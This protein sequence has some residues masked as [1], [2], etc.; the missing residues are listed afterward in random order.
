[1]ANYGYSGAGQGYSSDGGRYEMSSFD[2]A[3]SY[4]QLSY[5][6]GGKD[7]TTAFYDEVSSIQDEIR[8]FNANVLKISEMHTRSLNSI[9]DDATR[10]T[11]AQLEGL[12]D[13][14]RGLSGELKR[15][16]KDLE[17]RGGDQAKKQQTSF[18]KSK[19]M[20]SIQGYQQV[21]REYRTKYKQRIE[22]QL[23][24]VKPDATQEEVKAM[25]E[26]DDVQVFQQELLNSN[27]LG[28]SR[29]AYREVQARHADIK[30]I[31]KTLIELAQLFQ[32]MSIQV[33]QQEETINVIQNNAINIDHDVEQGFQHTVSAVQS[34]AGARR[35]RWICFG[36]TVAV[37]V[38]IIIIVLVQVHPWTLTTNN[39]NNN[40][41][42]ANTSTTA[43]GNGN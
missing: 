29:A 34:A 30:K 3:R 36:I 41:N 32:E 5:G 2:P 10:R 26:S 42:N 17:R 6:G 20:E 7:D 1:M 25:A 39:N 12:I 38:V 24:I 27:R 40:N 9:D 4:D 33:E 43:N 21:E 11:T 35:K 8:R 16:I 28:E 22:R 31:E 37:I 14:T 18:I 13:D 19:F 23:K 15:R